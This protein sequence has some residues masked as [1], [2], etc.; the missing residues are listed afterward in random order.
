MPTSHVS[1]WRNRRYSHHHSS[2]MTSRTP[3]H[4]NVGPRDDVSPDRLLWS[5]DWAAVPCFAVGCATT[6]G[7]VAFAGVLDFTTSRAWMTN[8]SRAEK[9]GLHVVS[10]SSASG[11]GPTTETCEG[12]TTSCW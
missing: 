1:G 2:P 3:P 8:R 10:V 4:A 5:D 9:R 6:I 12:G 7:T 11:V